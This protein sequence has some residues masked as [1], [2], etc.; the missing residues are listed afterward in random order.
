[1]LK[2]GADIVRYGNS[3]VAGGVR[4]EGGHLWLSKGPHS[5]YSVFPKDSSSLLY[6]SS[7][8]CEALHC[9]AER[10]AKWKT[11]FPSDVSGIAAEAK[12]HIIYHDPAIKNDHKVLHAVIANTIKRFLWWGYE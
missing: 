8:Q 4:W 11:D 3:D 10:I 9:E 7:R 5:S 1:M 12:R 6:T 2:S